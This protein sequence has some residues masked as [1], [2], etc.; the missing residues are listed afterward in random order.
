MTRWI[1]LRVTWICI[2]STIGDV[3]PG[4]AWSLSSS[5][6]P[7]AFNSPPTLAAAR[8]TVRTAPPSL[9]WTVLALTTGSVIPASGTRLPREAAAGA[10]SVIASWASASSTVDAVVHICLESRPSNEI[11]SG[12]LR[13]NTMLAASRT[14]TS[15]G[16]TGKEFRKPFHRPNGIAPNSSVS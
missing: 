7:A 13:R 14:S 5:G 10:V 16:S 11:C 4:A 12:R 8:W 1:R 6:A 15:A 3:A 9:I 2:P